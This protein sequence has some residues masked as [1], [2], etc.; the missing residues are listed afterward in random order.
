MITMTK[1]KKKMFNPIFFGWCFI[2][3]LLVQH[4]FGCVTN[5]GSFF[6][7]LNMKCGARLDHN[8]D[9]EDDDDWSLKKMMWSNEH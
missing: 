5:H 6:L 2:I 9:D 7:Q 3:D 1:A 4:E 8:I